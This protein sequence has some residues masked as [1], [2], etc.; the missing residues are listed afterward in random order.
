MTLS[1][2]DLNLMRVFLTVYRCQSI[3][4]AAEVLNLTQP[5][6]SGAL[7]RL[8][9]Q[10]GQ[11]LFVRDGRG[12]APTHLAHE[13]ARQIE[14]ALEAIE[15]TLTDAQEFTV[16]ASVDLLSTPQSQSCLSWYRKLKPIRVWVT[17][18]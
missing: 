15:N 8:Q 3:T 16:E 7:K 14:P 17:A 6:V 1:D 12:I 2:F 18:R 13:M 9:N 10:L 4:V 5:G 11:K